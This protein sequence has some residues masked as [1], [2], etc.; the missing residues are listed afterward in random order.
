M[1]TVI[2]NSLI[3]VDGA[4]LAAIDSDTIVLDNVNNRVGIGGVSSPSVPLQVNG[5]I[6]STNNTNS[7]LIS[8]DDGSIEIQRT[9]S[10]YIDFKTA[11]GEDHDVRLQ[12]VDNGFT[13]STGG[14]GA[15]TE[16]MRITSAGDVGIG[17]TSPDTILEI[18]DRA[19]VLQIRDTNTGISDNLATLRLA[20]TGAGDTTDNYYDLA[21]ENG[22]FIINYGNT[23]RVTIDRTTGYVGINTTGP[24]AFLHVDDQDGT[25]PTAIIEGGGTNQNTPAD[26]EQTLFLKTGDGTGDLSTGIGFFATFE[27]TPADTNDRRAT[28]IRAGFDGGA[29]GT[30]YMSFHVGKGTGSTNNDAE[31]MTDERLKITKTAVTATVPIN[32]DKGDV[33]QAPV[34]NQTATFT[35][36][37]GSSGEMFRIA[38]SVTNININVANFAEG[39]IVTLVNVSGTNTPTLTFDAWANG[40]RIA[41]GDGTNLAS[42]STTTL[43]AWGVVTLIAIANTRLT[44]NG[45]VS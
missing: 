11:A 28:D 43:D 12:Q 24:A 13:I 34:S 41:G 2:T 9:G 4:R 10:P 42:T 21:L 1:A 14:N 15:A 39:D 30:E 23:N 17:T 27:N 44:I 40:V 8:G 16:R 18:V 32:D 37:S 29:W 3:T 26:G 38:G 22:D 33:R 31:A 20:E 45:N 35:V 7:V 25:G 6:N 36:P 5:N 19:P